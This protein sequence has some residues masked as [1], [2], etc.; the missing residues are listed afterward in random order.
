MR[1]KLH[2][3]LYVGLVASACGS[4]GSPKGSGKPLGDVVAK[5]ATVKLD[6]LIFP[7]DGNDDLAAVSEGT[8]LVSNWKD[9]Y[10]RTVMR[11]EDGDGKLTLM[12]EQASLTDI[13]DEGESQTVVDFAMLTPMART[14]P[15]VKVDD[16]I[17]TSFSIPLAG[18][19]IFSDEALGLS[20]RIADGE[21]QLTPQLDLGVTIGGGTKFHALSTGVVTANLQ[22]VVSCEKAVAKSFV[23]TLWESPEFSIALPPIGPIPVSAQGKLVV[24]AGLDVSAMGKVTVTMG[25]STTTQIN[26]GAKYENGGWQQQGDTTASWQPMGPTLTTDVEAHAKIYLSA[27]AEVGLYGGLHL[28][29][30]GAGGVVGVSVEPYVQFDYPGLSAPWALRAGFTGHYWAALNI[31]DKQIA[32][33]DKPGDLLFDKSE[34]IAP[35][36]P[37][38]LPMDSGSCTNGIQDGSETDVDCGGASGGGSCPSCPIGLDC[39]ADQD[40]AD[41]S[42]TYGI[43]VRL[44]AATCTDGLHDGDEQDVDCGG[45]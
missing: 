17:G 39:I 34:Q 12:T 33:I 27:G 4:P 8:V 3:V 26:Y 35:A 31:L 32:G 45:S 1:S 36:I 24:R 20:V 40:C 14:W 18:K 41:G 43:C 44:I 22:L 9:G 13:V 19:Q 37:T 28:L 6:S 23:V 30:L 7:R 21:I 5:Q 29:K 16:A 15:G 25:A 38:G 11:V 10:L 2:V 42:C